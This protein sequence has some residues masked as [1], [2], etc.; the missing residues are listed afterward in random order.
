MTLGKLNEALGDLAKLTADTKSGR[1]GKGADAIAVGAAQPYKKGETT[2]GDIFSKQYPA[3]GRL[4]A[5]M[6]ENP[7][8]GSVVITG[9]ALAQLT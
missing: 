7:M 3:L 6:K 8:H 9:A 4:A 5:K 1:V 2:R